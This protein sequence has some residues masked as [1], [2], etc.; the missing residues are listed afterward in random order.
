MSVVTRLDGVE[1][2]V[3]WSSTGAGVKVRPAA[4]SRPH[5]AGRP[6]DPVREQ[7]RPAQPGRPVRSAVARSGS[8][9]SVR[10][11][12]SP[13]PARRTAQVPEWVLGLVMAVLLFL[14]VASVVAVVTGFWMVGGDSGVAVA[15]SVGAAGPIS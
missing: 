9:A 7:R 2:Q 14:F 6:G 15:T 12:V 11:C 10:A 5:T 4:P 3:R 1:G 8:V 13:A